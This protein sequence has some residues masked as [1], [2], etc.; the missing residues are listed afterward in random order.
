[1]A[2]Q[3]GPPDRPQLACSNWRRKENENTAFSLPFLSALLPV[4]IVDWIQQEVQSKGAL[5][6]YT[7]VSSPWNRVGYDVW[8]VG[9]EEEMEDS[10]HKEVT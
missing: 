4:L 8:G 2:W 5:A 7:Q 9:L 10:K 6:A 3:K 1:M